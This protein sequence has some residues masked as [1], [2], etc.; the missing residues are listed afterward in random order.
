MMH[1]QQ[2]KA[3]TNR[4]IDEASSKLIFINYDQ[5]EEQQVVHAHVCATDSQS[6]DEE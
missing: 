6:N 2:I 1:R 4:N 5:Q 3:L